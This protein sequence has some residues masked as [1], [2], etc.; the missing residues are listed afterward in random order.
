MM[1]IS[2]EGLELIKRF[3]GF[4]GTAYR[5]PAGVWTIGYGH[6]SGVK[7]GDVLTGKQAEMILKADL[8][9]VYSCIQNS[10]RVPLTSGQF[11]ALV[12]F[13]FNVGSGAFSKSTL[14]VMLN[15][16]DFHGAGHQLL[17]W[18]RAGGI[19]FKGLSERRRAELA[20]FES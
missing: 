2:A 4:R 12:S 15:A 20:L 19:V 7:S 17:R 3:E 1:K 16:G 5:C 10:V 6:T 9:V 11:S 18:D 13:V 14:L 8:E